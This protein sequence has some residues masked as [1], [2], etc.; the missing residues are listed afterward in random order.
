MIITD[1]AINQVITVCLIKAELDMLTNR[2]NNLI[3]LEEQLEYSGQ[4]SK[5][6][7]PQMISRNELLQLLRKNKNF[8]LSSSK[9]DTTMTLPL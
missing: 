3:D 1:E 4:D 5:T 6:Y 7:I 2:L 8:A 9:T